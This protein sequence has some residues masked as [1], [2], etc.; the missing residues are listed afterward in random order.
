MPAARTPGIFRRISQPVFR[1][2]RRGFVLAS[3]GAGSLLML[4]RIATAGEIS[5]LK[6]DVTINGRKASLDTPVF[7][8]DTVET[9]P[10]AQLIFKLNDDAFLMRANSSM[11]LEKKTQFDPL[12]SG[13][14]L[15]TG[16]LAVVFGKGQKKVYATTVT[17]G[18][19]GTGV[20]L[21]V[22][23]DVTYFCTCYGMVDL[24]ARE[25]GGLADKELV[26][27]TRHVSRYVYRD[28]PDRGS[29]IAEAPTINHTNEELAMLED[30]VGRSCPLM[31]GSK[32]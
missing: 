3:L 31:D 7:S 29:R 20:Y 14:R 12:I 25:E 9:G 30:L 1:Y 13:L 22:K 4:P 15:L 17:A 21:E 24:V 19:R 5:G 32:H 16:A 2:R 18:I 27:S 28:R 10:G 26:T 8:G 23:P 11:R 6:G